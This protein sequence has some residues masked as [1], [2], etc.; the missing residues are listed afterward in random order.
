MAHDIFISYSSKDKS[1]ADA[2]CASLEQMKVRCWI[3]PRD[4]LPGDS[5]AKV[6]ADSIAKS[7]IFILILSSGSNNSRHV[8]REVVLA[9]TKL[10]PGSPSRGAIQQRT[11]ICSSD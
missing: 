11:F 2:V 6:I 1:T 3:A 5:F 7:R 9:V 4:V 10:S 8:L